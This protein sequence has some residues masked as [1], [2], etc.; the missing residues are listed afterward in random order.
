MGLMDKLMG[1]KPGKEGVE[2]VS[3]DE[4]RA[5]LL[6]LSRDTAPWHV[7][8]PEGKEKGDLVGEWR[9]VDAQWQGIFSDFHLSKTFKVLMKFD[10]A[11]G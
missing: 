1:T 11:K 7:R 3:V 4:L 8:E 5:A 9:I 2:P 6:G 10:E